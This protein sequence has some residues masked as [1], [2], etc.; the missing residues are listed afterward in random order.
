MN[1]PYELDRRET[2][3][4]EGDGKGVDISTKN[5]GIAMLSTCHSLK[6]QVKCFLEKPNAVI[7]GNADIWYKY[8]DKADS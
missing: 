8:S 5:P 6:S 2:N 4:A 1:R 3:A 7:A